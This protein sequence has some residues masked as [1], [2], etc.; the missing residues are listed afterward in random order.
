MLNEIRLAYI[1]IQGKFNFNPKKVMT[2]YEIG[3][4]G[5]TLSMIYVVIIIQIED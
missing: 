5:A 3:A 4:I 2:A 1:S